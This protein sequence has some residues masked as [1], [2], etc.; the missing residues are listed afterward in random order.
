[1]PVSPWSTFVDRFKT[2]NREYAQHV[3]NVINAQLV[4][5]DM[6]AQSVRFERNVDRTLFLHVEFEHPWGVSLSLYDDGS[7]PQL[8]VRADVNL[9]DQRR[10]QH[11]IEPLSELFDTLCEMYRQIGEQA[12]F[13]WESTDP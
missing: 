3:V 8:R 11:I 6:R 1:M 9:E 5:L 12:E 4:G 13:T 7:Q 2:L 10:L